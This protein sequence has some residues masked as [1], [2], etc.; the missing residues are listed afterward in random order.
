MPHWCKISSSYLVPVR[1]YYT[2][3]KTTPQEKRFFWSNLYKIEIMITSS[4]RN[5]RVNKLWLY[6]HF[7][8]IIWTRWWNLLG[9]VMD[10][11]YDV[12]AI[13]SKSC[14]F[15]K[16]W[17]NHFCWHHQNYKFFIKAIFKDSRKVK[18]IISLVSKYNLHM[19]FLVYPNLLIFSEKLL[20]SA[21][22]MGG[23][24]W[25]DFWIFFR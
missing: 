11:N 7:H 19:Y 12:I 6:D 5:A 9:D 20:M 23:V 25:Y 15:K 14:Y 2:W 24:T 16:A 10:I 4:H 17:G 21:G 3:T 13:I 8:N 22:L 18:R 1:N